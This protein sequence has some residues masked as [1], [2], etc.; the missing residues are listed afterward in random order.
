M[1]EPL[2]VVSVADGV[3]RM[4]LNRADKRNAISAAMAALMHEA[5]EALDD[6]DDVRVIVVEGTDGAFSAG[7]DMAESNAS[8]EAG[9]RRFN[10][11]SDAAARVGASP[12]PTIAAIDGPVYGAG[13][14]LA[15]ACDI[16]VATARSRFRFPGSEYGLVVGAA[17]LA[18]LVGNALAKELIFTSRVVDAEEAVRI[19]LANRVVANDA[20]AATIDELTAQIAASSPLAAMWAKRVINAATSGN[21]VALEAQADL[22]LRGGADHRTRFASATQRITGRG[23]GA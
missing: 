23:S 14:L 4:R 17:G 12:K 8:Y 3:G 15:C 2:V 13:A 22:A 9:E 6:D 20:L 10:P 21:A 16:R 11:S 5:M 1:P 19:G 18:T 7:A